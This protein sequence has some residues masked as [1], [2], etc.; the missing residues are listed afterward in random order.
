MAHAG[1]PA[2]PVTPQCI[3]GVSQGFRRLRN[4]SAMSTAQLLFAQQLVLASAITWLR[5]LSP[6]PLAPIPFCHLIHIF[7]FHQ[8]SAKVLPTPRSLP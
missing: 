3:K 1:L 8:Y 6:T 2:L 4:V 7:S 5:R